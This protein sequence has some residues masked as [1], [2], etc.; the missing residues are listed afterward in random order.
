MTKM[1][2]H[3]RNCLAYWTL[4]VFER[5]MSIALAMVKDSQCF[6]S[7]MSYLLLLAV[8]VIKLYLFGT[9]KLEYFHPSMTSLLGCTEK[10]L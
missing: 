4:A 8:T 10:A 7:K 5:K 1:P 6:F 9:A 2:S 3:S